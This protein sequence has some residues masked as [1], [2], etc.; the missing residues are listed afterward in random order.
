MKGIT[1]TGSRTL[2]VAGFPDPTPG[3]RD[4]VLEMGASGMCGTDLGAYRSP[5]GRVP[6]GKFP[7][8]GPIIAGHEPCGV[9]VAIGSA[10]GD[11]EAAIGDRVMNHHYDGCGACRHCR[12]GWTQMCLEGAVAYGYGGHG[13]HA[14]YMV[15]PAHSLVPLP[16]QLSFQAGAAVACGTGTAYGALKR[17]GL[18]GDE[19]VAIFGQGP[20]GLSATLLAAEMGSRVIAVEISPERR[21]EALDWGAEVA[22]DPSAADPVEAILELTKGEGADKTVDCTSSVDARRAAVQSTRIWGTSCMVGIGGELSVDVTQDVIFRQ[23]NI[24]GHWTFS[25]TIQADCADFIAERGID[26]DRIF[27]HQWDIDQAAEAYSL[28]DQ[29]KTGKGVFTS[30]D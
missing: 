1:F 19:T 29:G 10:V 21:Q 28:F 30:F 9:V 15:V 23:L 5:D 24:V 26:L 17:I 16:E 20:V 14:K 22:I 4:V 11:D 6:V 27:T 12:T 2:A 18:A 25:K 3:P 8:D 7:I 13:A